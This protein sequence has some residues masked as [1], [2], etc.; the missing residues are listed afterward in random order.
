MQRGELAA[1]RGQM[2]AKIVHADFALMFAGHQ[3]QMLKA[4]FADRRAFTGNFRLIQGLAL[5]A[6][7][8]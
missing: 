7:T 5:D 3:Q 8:H 4:H 1:N 6:I 2:L